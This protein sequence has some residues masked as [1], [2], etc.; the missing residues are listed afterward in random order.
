MLIFIN[1]SNKYIFFTY[2]PFRIFV[3]IKYIN[4]YAQ[5]PFYQKNYLHYFEIYLVFYILLF[6]III[7]SK[8]VYFRY[9]RLLIN[10]GIF[11]SP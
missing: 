6:S 3:I 9:Y 2:K 8:I 11:Y 5:Y 7:T 4:L 10:S 1:I